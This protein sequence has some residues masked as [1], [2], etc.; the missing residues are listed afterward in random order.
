MAAKGDEGDVDVLAESLEAESAPPTATDASE[1]RR[2]P[3]PPDPPE[4]TVH[5]PET[6]PHLTDGS[7]AALL[8]FLITEY[9]RLTDATKAHR[10]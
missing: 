5:L 10:P 7:A 8:R 6:P 1:E 2:T 9:N 4:L 3:D